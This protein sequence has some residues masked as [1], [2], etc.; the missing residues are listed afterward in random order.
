[1]GTDIQATSSGGTLWGIDCISVLG[2]DSKESLRSQDRKQPSLGFGASH[3]SRERTFTIIS[4]WAEKPTL[5]N[6]EMAKSIPTKP[7]DR[8]AITGRFVT[9][10]YAATHPKTTEHERVPVSNPKK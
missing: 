10:Q 8:S 1:M 5:E 4:R 6:T 3:L 2:A 9:G 7:V